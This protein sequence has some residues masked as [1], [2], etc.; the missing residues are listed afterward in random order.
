MS[1]TTLAVM[2]VPGEQDRGQQVGLKDLVRK[3]CHGRRLH[4][5]DVLADPRGR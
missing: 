5:D 1:P 2:H 4:E 3:R